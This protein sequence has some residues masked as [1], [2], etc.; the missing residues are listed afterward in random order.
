MS[1]VCSTDGPLTEILKF[2][3]AKEL[4]RHVVSVQGYVEWFA[5]AFLRYT[6]TETRIN[7]DFTYYTIDHCHQIFR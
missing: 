1:R 7:F 5:V 4:D 2:Q 3:L 6:R